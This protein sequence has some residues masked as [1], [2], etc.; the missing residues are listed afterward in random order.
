MEAIISATVSAIIAEIVAQFKSPDPWLI[1]GLFGQ[2]L[3]S[4]R[5]LWQWLHSERVGQSVI[6]PAFWYF[7]IGGGVTLLIYAIHKKDPVFILGQA[8]GI[9]IYLRNVQFLFRAR[10]AE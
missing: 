7:S 5:F 8:F 9:L 10:K 2:G 6:P 4:A 1:F 3:F